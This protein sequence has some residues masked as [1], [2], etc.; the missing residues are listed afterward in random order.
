MEKPRASPPPRG[1]V[2]YLRGMRRRDIWFD[3]RGEG[4]P[5]FEKSLPASAIP[6]EALSV[7][8]P[9]VLGFIPKLTLDIPA[10]IRAHRREMPWLIQTA[11]SY[12]DRERP[13]NFNR[14]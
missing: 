11:D 2:P 8:I 10:K 4:P 5:R 9:A 14:A 3:Y 12:E 1:A 7:I 13:K 6:L